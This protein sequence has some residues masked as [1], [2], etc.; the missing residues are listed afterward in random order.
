[1]AFP[2]LA[3]M[4]ASR[5]DWIVVAQTTVMG[6]S[7]V[8]IFYPRLHPALPSLIERF[9]NDLFLGVGL[10]AIGAALLWL[11]IT[12]N[13]NTAVVSGDL[14]TDH[15]LGDFGTGLASQ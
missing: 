10:T 14:S 3:V 11:C 13:W 2:L 5:L 7:S 4:P 6:V 15:A 9:G 1:M 8:P 12:G